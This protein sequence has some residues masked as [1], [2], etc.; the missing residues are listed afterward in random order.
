MMANTLDWSLEEQGLLSIRSRGHFNRT[1]PPMEQAQQ[2]A[3][4]TGNYIM[5]I[6]MLI[7]IAAIQQYRHRRR[8]RHYS[9]TLAV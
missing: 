9:K 6:V 3:W 4:E 8:D 7:A 5:A 2:L 1:L